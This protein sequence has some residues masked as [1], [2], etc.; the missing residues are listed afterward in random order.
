MFIPLDFLKD[1]VME[2]KS[3]ASLLLVSTALIVSASALAGS[4]HHGKG[5]FMALFD[6][7]NDDVVTMEEFRLAAAERFGKMDADG[8]GAV[9]KDEFRSYI[10]EKRQKRNGM[11]FSKI[12]VDGN[13]TVS[14]AEYLDYKRQKAESRFARMDKNNDG[15][16]SADEFKSKRRHGKWSRGCGKGGIFAKLD[17]NADG[18]ITRDE[19]LTAWSQWFAKIDSNGDEVVT[20]DEVREY[21]NKKFS[22]KQ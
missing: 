13:G 9:S 2:K 19:S 14:Q 18:E 3:V 11:K 8:S 15:M 6:S 16:L 10:T 1:F 12:D 22:S 20:A 21:R 5:P 4:D 7:N 17:K